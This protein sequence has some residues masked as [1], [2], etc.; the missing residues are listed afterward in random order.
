[1]QIHPSSIN[2][3]FN[4]EFRE[5]YSILL[6]LDDQAKT[7]DKSNDKLATAIYNYAKTFQAFA[8]KNTRS[9]T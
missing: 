4:K 1:M 9:A 2:A 5:I 8:K 3:D 7:A 6:S